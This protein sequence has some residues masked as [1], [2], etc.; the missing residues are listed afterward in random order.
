MPYAPGRI[1]LGP[2]L[3][4]VVTWLIGINVATF[5]LFAFSSASVRLT[6]AQW[7]VLTP[8]GLARGHVWK[9]LTTAFFTVDGLA[10]FLDLLVL[11]MFVPTLEAAWGRNRFL[12]FFALTVVAGNLTAAL[13]GL[14]IG[15]LGT[16]IL[17]MAPFIYGAIVA[18]GVE[19]G[20]QPVQF[21]GVIPMK[22]R[23]LAIGIAVVMLL[24]VFLNGDWVN[25]VGWI[26]SMVAAIGFAGSPRLWLMHFRRA[27]MKRKYTVLRG[28]SSSRSGGDGPRWLN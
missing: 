25:G 18:F 27:R 24:A 20:D 16:P 10:F 15:A 14:L 9:L 19:W 2:R 13:F 21:F 22:G 8:A 12:K 26:A 28:G 4:P 5:L 11:W 6:L 7:L 3:T 1:R 23:T 17:G